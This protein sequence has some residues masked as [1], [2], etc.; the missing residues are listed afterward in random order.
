[1]IDTLVSKISFIMSLS[2]FKTILAHIFSIFVANTTFITPVHT[3]LCTCDNLIPEKVWQIDFAQQIQKVSFLSRFSWTSMSF[4]QLLH[5]SFLT[6]AMICVCTSK[7]MYIVLFD[8]VLINSN[9]IM[10]LSVTFNSIFD[11]FKTIL[12]LCY[13][14]AKRIN[15]P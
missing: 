15:Y 6:N 2:S 13:I 12:L 7:V 3:A 4:L 10:L 14:Q 8:G 1:M 9:R 5:F 11:F